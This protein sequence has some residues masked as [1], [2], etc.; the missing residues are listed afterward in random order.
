MSHA[1]TTE[2][3]TVNVITAE[4]CHR[5][6]HDGTKVIAL[7]NSTGTTKTA[8]HLYCGTQA[9]CEAEITRLNLSPLP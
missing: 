9:E 8:H 4:D 5:L 3:I 1:T 6:I 7:F 2:Q